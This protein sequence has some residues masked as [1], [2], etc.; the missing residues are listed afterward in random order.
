LVFLAM[1]SL[2]LTHGRAVIIGRDRSPL[3]R[4]SGRQDPV[5]LL[6]SGKTS[7]IRWRPV[8]R[9]LI[10]GDTPGGHHVYIDAPSECR[11]LRHA[12]ASHSA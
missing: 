9:W 8:F 1:P 4:A 12:L 11:R 5:E 6:W 2:W 10:R 3:V 7:D